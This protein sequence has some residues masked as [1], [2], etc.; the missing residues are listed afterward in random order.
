MVVE[1]DSGRHRDSVAQKILEALA[2]PFTI[3]GREV[4]T[5]ASIGISLYPKDGHDVEIAE[6]RRCGHVPRQG[7]E[8]QL[9]PFLRRGYE[10]QGGRAHG[11]RTSLRHALDN[12]ELEVHYQP[13]VDLYIGEIVGVEALLR[14][15][16]PDLGLVSPARFIP[17]AEETGLIFPIGEWVMRNTCA[18]NKAWQDAGVITLPVSVNLSAR[19]FRQSNC[20]TSPGCCGN[21]A[22]RA[23]SGTGD[24]RKHDYG[25]CERVIKVMGN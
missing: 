21:R 19:Q 8:P 17:L 14:W 13:Q 10:R 18:Q 3:Y 24:D 7:A 1:M 16:H 23:L 12:G 2:S 5:C 11:R 25:G 4:L 15:Q 20:P 9:V 22:S 6:K